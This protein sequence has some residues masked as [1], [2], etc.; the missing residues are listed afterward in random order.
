MKTKTFA[1]W[2]IAVLATIFIASARSADKLP[3][4]VVPAS[5]GTM[6]GA[7]ASDVTASWA[8]TNSQPLYL[9]PR[10]WQRCAAS[11]SQT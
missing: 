2:V 5:A 4:V 8:S 3:N 6:A 1:L 11:K 9:R 7:A 10:S